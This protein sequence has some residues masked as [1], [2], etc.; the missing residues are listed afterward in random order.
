MFFD[1]WKDKNKEESIFIEHKK[2]CRGVGAEGEGQKGE[3]QGVYGETSTTDRRANER[4]YNP[5]IKDRIAWESG[6]I[7]G[8]N[9]FRSTGVKLRKQFEFERETNR[10]N[11]VK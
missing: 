4:K 7:P 2:F 3:V 1:R 6:P 9:A 10:I 11:G 5:K 8:I